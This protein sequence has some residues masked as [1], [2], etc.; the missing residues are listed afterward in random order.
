M[1]APEVFDALDRLIASSGPAARPGLVVAL[2]AR[3]AQLGAT[4]AAPT[5]SGNGRPAEEP[6]RLLTPEQAAEVASIP[7]K[8][9]YEW[10]RG[11]RWANRPTRRTLRIEER[12]FRAW[13]SSRR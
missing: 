8:R 9:L 2:A 3:L 10:A 1:T 4:L 11:K 5:T 12:G 13:L 7:V 6:E